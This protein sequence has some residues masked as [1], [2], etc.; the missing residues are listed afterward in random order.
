MKGKNIITAICVAAIVGTLLN[1]INNFDVF[2]QGRF[3]VRNT[4]KITLTYLTP[5]LVSLY[6]ALKAGRHMV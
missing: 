5:F 3:T 6:S 4:M 1:L 2:A